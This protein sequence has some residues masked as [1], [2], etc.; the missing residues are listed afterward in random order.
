MRQFLLS[1]ERCRGSM[2][3][4]D[5]RIHV[6]TSYTLRRIHLLRTRKGGVRTGSLGSIHG[7][8]DREPINAGSRGGH[9]NLRQQRNRVRW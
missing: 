4:I 3:A 1:Y 9:L 2:G 8:F 6:F 7:R 5:V